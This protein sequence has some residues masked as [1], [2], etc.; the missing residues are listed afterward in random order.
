MKSKPRE[1]IRYAILLA[2]LGAVVAVVGANLLWMVWARLAPAL[3]LD[4]YAERA[5]LLARIVTPALWI[6]LTSGVLLIFV[7]APERLNQ[8]LRV[9]L[10]NRFRVFGNR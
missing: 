1:L 8:W 6:T 5:A 9:R 2:G 4:E 3:Y 10:S 7:G